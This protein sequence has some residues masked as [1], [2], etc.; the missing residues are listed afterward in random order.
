MK[1]K[2]FLSITSQGNSLTTYIQSDFSDF[3]S[4]VTSMATINSL[5][6]ALVINDP[7]AFAEEYWKSHKRKLFV[8]IQ[9]NSD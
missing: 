2:G 9:N 4:S 8:S 1:K 3:S 6:F 5:N 7:K